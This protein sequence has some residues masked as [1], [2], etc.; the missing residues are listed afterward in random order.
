MLDEVSWAASAGELM[1]VMGAS[2]AGK[3]TMLSA[4]SGNLPASLGGSG[5]DGNDG[6]GHGRAG[7]GNQTSQPPRQSGNGGG[8]G[9]GGVTG[10]VL[11]N[12][13]PLAALP[14]SAIAYV[15]MREDAGR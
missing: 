12:G 15:M 7:S 5:G 2:G 6:G 13:L 3:S 1:A 11:F 4:I 10:D 14:P 8:S 9:S